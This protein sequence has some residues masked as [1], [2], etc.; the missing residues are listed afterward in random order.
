[1]KTR[2]I[3][4]LLAVCVLAATLIA[5]LSRGP[6]QEVRFD[7]KVP[8]EL[9]QATLEDGMHYLANWPMWFHMVAGVQRLG[10]DGQPL[11]P[12]G[13]VAEQGASIRLIVEPRSQSWRRFV[14]DFDLTEYVRG[15]KLVLKLRSD[16][17]RK[18]THLLD[19]LEWSVEL[20][21]ES[22]QLLLEGHASARTRSMRGRFFARAAPRIL[23]NQV[24]Y[25]DL[26][27]L[28]GLSSPFHGVGE[29]PSKPAR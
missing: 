27:A 26:I 24:Y 16:P 2:A 9:P 23:M 10:P 12:S 25:P 20:T 13:Q 15:R 18:I 6:D 8:T 7:R 14:L 29:I 3:W 21:R 11:P 19:G 22:G 28:S 1:M 4:V 17:G 5:W